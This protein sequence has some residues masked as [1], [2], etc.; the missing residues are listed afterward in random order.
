MLWFLTS[1][2]STLQ[3]RA[4]LEML[5]ATE[6]NI[7]S[8]EKSD[9]LHGVL[10]CQISPLGF[11]VQPLRLNIWSSI[12]PGAAGLADHMWGRMQ[13]SENWEKRR[14]LAGTSYPRLVPT[15]LTQFPVVPAPKSH[16]LLSSHGKIWVTLQEQSS[17]DHRMQL[18]RWKPFPDKPQVPYPAL[19][20]CRTI[21]QVN[22]TKSSS[23]HGSPLFPF[24]LKISHQGRQDL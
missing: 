4:N 8:G 1:R 6:S 17:A 22:A 23:Q 20:I 7:I 2:L 12:S 19:A 11:P 16:W 21:T 15:P 24:L 3:P 10:I 18:Q 5:S 9:L 14:F 13:T